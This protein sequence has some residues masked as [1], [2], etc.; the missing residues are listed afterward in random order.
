MAQRHLRI[1]KD[2]ALELDGAP[3][4]LEEYEE[5]L[6]LDRKLGDTTPIKVHVPLF[7]DEASPVGQAFQWLLE[8]ADQYR[9]PVDMIAGQPD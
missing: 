8:L 3:I 6:K 4:N 1:S 2:G 5:I 9:H 7:T